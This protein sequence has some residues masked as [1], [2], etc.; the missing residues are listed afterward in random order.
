MVPE[1][2]NLTLALK[3]CVGSVALG[4]GILLLYMLLQKTAE[5]LIGNILAMGKGEGMIIFLVIVGLFTLSSIL[6]F[7]AMVLSVGEILGSKK[8]GFWKLAWVLACFFIYVLGVP[9]YYLVGR[10]ELE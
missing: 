4:F 3:G 9:M 1:N 8:D 10:K 5:A 2:K 7:I 6:Y